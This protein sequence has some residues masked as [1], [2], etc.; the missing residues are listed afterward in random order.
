MKPRKLIGFLIVSIIIQAATFIGN[1]FLFA[2]NG[3]LQLDSQV[4][5]TITCDTVA[6][7]IGILLS[8]CLLVSKTTDT[9]S[10]HLFTWLI[11]VNFFILQSGI[12]SLF[13]NGNKDYLIMNK[14]A[15]FFF[16]F[17]GLMLLIIFFHYLVVY[18]NLYSK[19]Y[20]IVIG[21]FDSI[22]LIYLILAILNYFLGFYYYFDENGNYFRGSLFYLSIGLSA[23]T[24]ILVIIILFTL[25]EPFGKKISFFTYIT[26]PIIGMI[27]QM[28]TGYALTNVGVMI[29]L[30]I[31]FLINYAYQNSVL[32]KKNLEL[33]NQK[34]KLMFSQIQPHFLYN[35]LSAIMGID[36]CGKKT[37]NAIADFSDY[38]RGNLNLLV[39]EKMI[40]F[41]KEIEHTNAYLRLQN[42]RTPNKVNVS[43]DIEE[44]EFLIPPISLQI[45]IE[46]AVKYAFKGK[47]KGNIDVNSYLKDDSYYIEVIDDGN[48]FDDNIAFDDT[49]TGLRYLKSRLETTCNGILT[50]KSK[51]GFGTTATIIIPK[52]KK[53]IENNPS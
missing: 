49:H 39:N 19:K 25:K 24:F 7:L 13:F 51:V 27:I 4:I 20:R 6:I 42:L 50:I 44:D 37:F 10:F 38:L 1:L 26:I 18:F 52:E 2:N 21:V 23:F 9:G 35:S 22:G 30:L 29:S 12:I 5:V 45:L 33:E 11:L 3:F 28:F 46:N 17:L 15:N 47:D 14:L 48:G 40:T 53:E 31:L 43:Y 41:A 8:A 16:Y 32:I 34:V 36:D